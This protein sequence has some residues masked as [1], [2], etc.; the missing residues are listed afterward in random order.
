MLTHYV[1]GSAGSNLMNQIRI[2]QL[3]S[4][5][6]VLGLKQEYMANWLSQSAAHPV[7]SRLLVTSIVFCVVF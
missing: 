2:Q 5:V 4:P 6:K 3:T 7:I 1:S